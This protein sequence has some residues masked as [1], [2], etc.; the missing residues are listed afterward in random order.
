MQFDKPLSNTF[1]SK[2]FDL[3]LSIKHDPIAVSNPI[4]KGVSHFSQSLLARGF[5]VENRTKDLETAHLL[6]MDYG[7][8]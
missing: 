5:L 2:G 1:V 7:E 6:L 8:E 4:G 3:E